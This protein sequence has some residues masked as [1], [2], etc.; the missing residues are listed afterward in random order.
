[1][2]SLLHDKLVVD[3][4]PSLDNSLPNIPIH[5]GVP[6]TVACQLK[7]D[8]SRAMIISQLYGKRAASKR[9]FD[10][11]LGFEQAANPVAYE[12]FFP[13]TAPSQDGGCPRCSIHL[14]R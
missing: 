6:D 13:G 9:L 2:L 7:Y 10:N 3:L 12:P 8:P 1:M 5:H 4:L 14:P 11:V